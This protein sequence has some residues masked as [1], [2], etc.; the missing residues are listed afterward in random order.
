[1][2]SSKMILQQKQ[3]EETGINFNDAVTGAGE[4]IALDFE[5]VADGGGYDEG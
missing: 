1:M 4:E 2:I 5:E 3:G